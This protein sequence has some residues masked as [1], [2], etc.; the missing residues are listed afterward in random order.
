MKNKR[1]T[2]VQIPTTSPI[3][4]DQWIDEM[5]PKTPEMRAIE[6][7]ESIKYH[8]VVALAKARKAAGYT[9]AELAKKMGV[10]QSLI[11]RWENVNQNHTLETLLQ[12]CHAVNA[13]LVIGIKT[14]D[15]FIP[16]TS[17]TEHPVSLPQNLILEKPRDSNTVTIPVKKAAVE[18]TPTSMISSPARFVSSY[19]HSPTTSNILK[20]PPTRYEI[21]P[22]TL[23]IIGGE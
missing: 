1:T 3:D 11:S 2:K 12:L 9:Q 15:E 5:I 18:I 20:L 10:K 13:E 19:Q 6:I 14:V 8:L 17:A 4:L 22:R 21:A 7:E 16:I 23:G